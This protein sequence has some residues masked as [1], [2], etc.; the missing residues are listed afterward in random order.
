[1][2]W[3]LAV[4][5]TVELDSVP[6]ASL[7]VKADGGAG[8]QVPVLVFHIDHQRAGAAAVLGGTD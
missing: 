6:W 4:V 3:P 1:V 7:S 5:I 2:A 8:N